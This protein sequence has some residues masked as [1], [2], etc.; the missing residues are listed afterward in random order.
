AACQVLGARGVDYDCFEKGSMIGGNW[1]YEN[2][3]GTSSAYRSLHIN[4]ARKLMSFRSFPMPDSYPDYPSHWQVAKYFDDFA[5]R[6]GLNEKIA[7]NTEVVGVRDLS[8]SGRQEANAAEGEWEVTV[9]GPDGERRTERYRAVLVAN[10]HHWKPRWPEPPFP[11][12]DAYEGEQMHVHHYREPDVLEGRR[13]LVLGIGNSAVDVAVES[14]RIAAKTFM[15]MRRSAYVIP[16]FLG[17]KPIDEA[18]PPIATYLPMSVRRFFMKRLLKLSVGEMGDYGL[19]EPDHKLLEAHPT[20]SS[21]LLPRIGHGDITVKPNIDRF[22][23]GRT[24]R[25]ADGSEEEI[26]LTIYCTGYEIEFPFLDAG[27]FAARDNRMPLYKRAV[28]VES[29]GLYFVGF[30][31]PL[32]PIMPLAEAQ[33]EWIADLLGGRA[34]LPPAAEMRKEIAG[35]E[36]WMDRRFV[37]SKRHTIEVDFHPYMREIR[38][39]R[40]RRSPQ[41]A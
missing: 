24:V 37:S 16:K 41:A 27:V 32:G 18:T 5:E 34:A 11:G 31:Q 13:V 19:A 15:A 39:E 8:D 6:F 12:A 38:R 30:I 33:C 21:E 22:A 14:S 23:G 29:P 20:V 3:N 9:E 40:K 4:S 26:D 1:R 2:D 35:Y 36:R 10:G 7:F 17:G 28:A 25:F